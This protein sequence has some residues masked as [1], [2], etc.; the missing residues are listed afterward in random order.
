MNFGETKIGNII[1][2]I[3]LVNN[4]L[5]I[6]HIPLDGKVDIKQIEKQKQLDEKE[7][8]KFVKNWKEGDLRN[9]C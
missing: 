9:Y 3:D 4:E 6:T 8:E 7:F 1:R 2:K 5:T